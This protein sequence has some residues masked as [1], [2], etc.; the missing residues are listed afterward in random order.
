MLRCAIVGPEAVIPPSRPCLRAKRA[1]DSH[2]ATARNRALSAPHVEAGGDLDQVAARYSPFCSL[3]ED[4]D[5]LCLIGFL[6][7]ESYL[8]NSNKHGILSMDTDVLGFFI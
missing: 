2:A 7:I 3:F 5:K 6:F 1:S 4:A 8:Q